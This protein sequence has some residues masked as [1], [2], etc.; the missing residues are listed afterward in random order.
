MVSSACGIPTT[1][2]ALSVN[3]TAVNAPGN[4]S[5]NL[6]PRDGPSV[7]TV[8][9]SFSPSRATI[10]DN[11]HVLL[12]RDGLGTIAAL[13]SLPGGRVVHLIIDVNGYYQ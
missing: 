4:G 12:S 10:A 9:V 1:A 6:Y 7:T 11:A 13:A 2:K 3:V 8:V 5:I